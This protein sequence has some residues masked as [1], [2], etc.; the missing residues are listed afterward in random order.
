MHLIS[1]YARVDCA[2]SKTL[3]NR[4]KK[5]SATVMFD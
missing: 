4:V 1:Q 5:W 3:Q 2:S